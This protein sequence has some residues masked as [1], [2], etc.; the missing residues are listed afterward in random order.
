MPRCPWLWSAGNA[1]FPSELPLTLFDYALF[2]GADSHQFEMRPALKLPN[3]VMLMPRPFGLCPFANGE[4]TGHYCSVFTAISGQN[5]GFGGGREPPPVSWIASERGLSPHRLA[6][7]LTLLGCFFLSW[8]LIRWPE[9]NFTIS[10]AAFLMAL[11]TLLFSGGLNAAL[12]GRVTAL[13]IA[14]VLLLLGGLFIGS[15]VSDQ[16]GRWFVIAAQYFIALMVLPIVCVSFDRDFLN[17]AS[18]AFTYGVAVSQVLGILALQLFGYHALTPYVGR[19]VV[20]GNDRIGAMTAEPNA[21]GAVCAFA[22]II[23]VS[24][25]IEGRVRLGFGAIIAATILAGMVFSASF[26]ALMAL[27]VSIGLIALLTWSNGFKRIGVPI[28]MMAVL[29][30]GFGGPLPE[31]FVERVAEA[32][33]GLDLSKAGTF[34]SRAALIGEAWSNADDHLII[35]MGVDRYREASVHGAPV[36]NLALLLL[37]EGGVLSFVGLTSLLLCLFSSAIMVSRSDQIGGAVCFATLAVILLYTMSIP[38]MYAR[39]WFGPVALIFALYMAP[40]VGLLAFGGPPEPAAQA[41][42][43]GTIA[44]VPQHGTFPR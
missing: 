8:Q 33:V 39:H 20:L 31:V 5:S 19:T 21:N 36:H 24:A 44:K 43:Q 25:I 7:W 3:D 2:D 4:G 17:R 14:G 15:I 16:A 11:A 9:L 29:Y 10:D 12:F 13:W 22:M 18:L 32:V 41:G 40:K 6:R 1:T 38:H 35:G 23:L 28:L 27:F 30:V 37:N 26:T 34:V 42:Y